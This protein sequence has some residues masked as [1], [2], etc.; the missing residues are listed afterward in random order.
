M[1]EKKLFGGAHVRRLRRDRKLT[2]TRMAEELGLSVSYLNLI[3]RNQR[4]L[5]AQ[6]ILKLAE[7]YDIDFKIFANS[8][9]DYV[10]AE[11]NE[12]FR[13]RLFRDQPVP[14]Q[15]IRELT[16]AC[17]TLAQGVTRLF[18]AYSDAIRLRDSAAMPSDSASDMPDNPLDQIRDHIQTHRNYFPSLDEAAE[19]LNDELLLESDNL[20]SAVRERLRTKF[21]IDMRIMPIEVMSENLRRFD[22]HRKQLMLS[23]ILS[24]PSRTFQAAHQL[25][26]IEFPQ[27]INQ[28]IAEGG[29]TDD[30]AKRLARVN[31]ANY[32]AAAL[33]MPYA[34]F[35]DAAEQSGYDIELL[36]LK[37][38]ASYEQVCHRLTTLQRAGTRGVPMFMIR[39]DQAGNVSKRFSAGRFHFSTYGGT[40]PLWNIHSSFK[41]PGRVFTQIVEMG[42][43]TRYFSIARTVKR[44]GHLRSHSSDEPESELAIGLGCELKYAERL[45]Y[46]KGYELKNPIATPIGINCSLCDRENCSQRAHPPISRSVIVDERARTISPFVFQEG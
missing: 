43:G 4:P 42:D 17:P 27:L 35:F 29:F 2:Q 1:S 25:V 11:L 20:L 5:S 24:Q 46:A 34:K 18:R 19:S 44:Q 14:N 33:M 22:R 39:I 7:T 26:L 45:S 3:E 41:I 8:E 6:F 12:V 13:D 21:A 10:F 16:E 36:A 9:E 28:T 40:C 31:F 30:T 37:F 38:G 32:F 15:E 23:E